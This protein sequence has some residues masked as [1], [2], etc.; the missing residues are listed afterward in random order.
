MALA[1]IILAV[2]SLAL[3]G[4]SLRN[5]R[6][7]RRANKALAE[8]RAQPQPIIPWNQIIG[9]QAGGSVYRPD[10]VNIITRPD[11]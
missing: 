2:V 9:Y 7:L 11:A 3:G 1:A 5:L 8:L 6:R 10:Q 4:C